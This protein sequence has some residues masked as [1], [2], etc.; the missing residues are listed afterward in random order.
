MTSMSASLRALPGLMGLFIDAGGGLSDMV[1]MGS[2]RFCEAQA[3]PQSGVGHHP[4]GETQPSFACG[5]K[6]NTRTVHGVRTRPQRI[7]HTQVLGVDRWVACDREG[8]GQKRGCG[9]G[10]AKRRGKAAIPG[11]KTRGIAGLRGFEGLLCT[12]L[13]SNTQS[14]PFYPDLG[15]C[16]VCRRPHVSA[17]RGFRSACAVEHCVWG[18]ASFSR[19]VPVS[20]ATCVQCIAVQCS[21]RLRPMFPR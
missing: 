6:V 12:R 20:D 1:T 3:K 2:V 16:R 5:C 18:A 17:Y 21:A 11:E 8:H 14:G 10:R 13:A 19:R 7:A 4:C 15:A 9:N